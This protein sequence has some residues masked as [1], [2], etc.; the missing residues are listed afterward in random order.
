MEALFQSGNFA[1]FLG[2]ALLAW[3]GIHLVRAGSRGG[4][5]LTSGAFF[6]AFSVI[7]KLYIEPSLVKPIHLSFSHSTITL[8]TATPTLTLSLGSILIPLGLLMVAAAQQKG[9]LQ[10]AESRQT[11]SQS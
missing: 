5:L 7:F 4:W 10:P 6:V 2:L 8:I 1:G 11:S 3:V 9:Q